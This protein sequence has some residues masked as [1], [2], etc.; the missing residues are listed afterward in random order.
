MESFDPFAET[1]V[2]NGTQRIHVADSPEVR[3]KD[4]RFGPYVNE[5]IEVP[6]SVAVLLVAKGVALPVK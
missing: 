1:V 6:L 3:I 5:T 2:F 4:Q